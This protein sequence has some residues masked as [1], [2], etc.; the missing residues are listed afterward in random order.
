MKAGTKE[1]PALG[2][3]DVQA[4]GSPQPLAPEPALT[5]WSF[6]SCGRFRYPGPGVHWSWKQLFLTSTRRK[7]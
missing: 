4:A 2:W 1:R 7:S 3:G 6:P 5:P